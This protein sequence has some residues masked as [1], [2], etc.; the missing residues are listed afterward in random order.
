MQ[1][2][3]NVLA[4]SSFVVSAAV[5]GSGIYVYKNK[6]TLI[7]Q[8]LPLPSLDNVQIP[9]TSSPLPISLPF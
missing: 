5:V 7:K 4:L 3:V 2:L 9:S 6:D 8:I 1:T